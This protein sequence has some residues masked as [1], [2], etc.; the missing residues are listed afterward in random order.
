MPAASTKSRSKQS[1]VKSTSSE[2]SKDS[3]PRRPS[4]NSFKSK[5]GDSE[6]DFV[7]EKNVDGWT[8][9][10]SGD[11]SYDLTEPDVSSHSIASKKSTKSSKSNS[12]KKSN[13]SSASSKKSTERKSLKKKKKS[14]SGGASV[15]STAS[16]KKKSKPRMLCLHGWRSC[17]EA[18]EM[19]LQHLNLLDRF[20]VEHVPAPFASKKAE[21]PEIE[22][23]A[24]EF[25]SWIKR[26]SS[27]KKLNPK[28]EKHELHE[29]LLAVLQFC[30]ER[31]HVYDM[32]YGFSQGALIVTLLSHNH[33]RHALLK[34]L[35]RRDKTIDTSLFQYQ[36]PWKLVLLACAAH[37]DSA[38]KH[39]HSEQPLPGSLAVPSVHLIGDEDLLHKD[40]SRKM[41]R[42][43]EKEARLII[44]LDQVGHELP[45]SLQANQAIYEQIYE[46]YQEEKE[47]ILAEERLAREE[48][49]ALAE[50]GSMW[51]RMRGRSS[52]RGRSVSGRSPSRGRSVNGRSPSVASRRSPSRGVSLSRNGRSRSRG[53]SVGV[54][55][56]H[57]LRQQIRSKSR[58]PRRKLAEHPDKADGGDGQAEKAKPRRGLS[59]SRTAR[60]SNSGRKLVKDADKEDIQA[61][62]M[63]PLLQD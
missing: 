10:F 57:E 3:A 49:E 11:G 22:K 63:C 51:D 18:T 33:I 14:V 34:E 54:Q 61:S 41:A 62:T 46:W 53:R 40:D 28:D 2:L 13:R 27:D 45:Q 1:S 30:L 4:R 37:R 59:S 55:E 31:N 39:E 9:D 21:N 58:G 56:R 47:L 19:Q 15:K 20:T 7:L 29:S 17:P 38:W 32:V 43:F 16:S 42:F 35:H 23:L 52:S 12:S 36:P 44:T 50:R 5:G 26:N 24:K 48:E 25:Y 60:I 6:S 8:A